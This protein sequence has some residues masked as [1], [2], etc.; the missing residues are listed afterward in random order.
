M[1]RIIKNIFAIFI[2]RRKPKQTLPAYEEIELNFQLR[3]VK[4][5]TEYRYFRTLNSL[6]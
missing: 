4:I 5:G 2:D 1:K 3:F 6:F